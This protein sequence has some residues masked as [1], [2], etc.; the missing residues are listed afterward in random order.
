MC[1]KLFSN[2]DF[3]RSVLEKYHLSAL[4]KR[5][6]E[7]AAAPSAQGSPNVVSGA[8]SLPAARNVYAPPPERNFLNDPWP[9]PQ[10][11]PLLLIFLLPVAFFTWLALRGAGPGR[12]ILRTPPPEPGGLPALPESLQVVTG[13]GVRYAVY[14]LSGMLLQ[15]ESNTYRQS[16]SQ[17]TGG[18]A[19][20]MGGGQV[21]YTPPQ[22][23]THTETT[24]EEIIWVRTPDNRE[25]P[26]TLYNSQFQSRPGQIVS[27]LVRPL[28]SDTGD[29]ILAYNHATGNMEMCP[30]MEKAHGTG[31]FVRREIVQWTANLTAAAGS[32]IV[33]M[34]YLPMYYKGQLYAGFLVW[35]LFGT[36]VLVTISFL[37]V[38]PML[39]KMVRKRRHASFK[40]KYMPGLRQFFEQGTATLQ[41]TFGRV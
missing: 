6:R 19:I 40:R 39:T 41:R 25:K 31:G 18:Q 32:A 28:T 27:I 12:R 30:A 35:W 29:I 22:T 17:T 16:Y 10:S 7:A 4:V 36:V 11:F 24:R 37:M 5:Q 13:P 26:W 1:D 15:K 33:T 3:G 9:Y 34:R 23:T 20:Q 8:A 21:Q 38:T 2:A 14:V